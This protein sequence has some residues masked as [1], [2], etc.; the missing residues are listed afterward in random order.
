MTNSQNDLIEKL[1]EKLREIFQF[2][3]EDL[4]FGIYRI[5]NYKRKEIENFINKEIINEVKTQLSVLKEEEQQEIEEKIKEITSKTTIKKYLE[6]LEKG[7]EERIKLYREDFAED[8][9]EYENLKRKLKQAKVSENIEREIYNHLINFFSRYYDKGDFISKRRYGKKEKYIVPYNGEEILFYWVNKD[10]YYIKTTEYFRKYSFQIPDGNITVNFKVVKAEEEKGN[11]KSVEKKFFILSPEVFSLN[12]KELNIYFEYRTLSEKEKEKYKQGNTISQEKINKE[13]VKILQEKI[14]ENSLARIIF[15]KDPSSRTGKSYIEKHLYNYTKRNLTDYFI[16]KDLK[17]FL[18]R[19]LDFYIKNELLQLENLEILEQ[20]EYFDKL[21]LYLSEVKVFKN[22]ASK[23]I[24]FLAQ[25]ENFQ[26]KLWEKKKF[27]IDTHYVITLDKIKEYAGEEFLNDILSEILNNEKQLK[28]WQELFGIN[29]KEKKDLIDNNTLQGIEWKKL[30]IDTKH[31]NENFKWK[32]LTA[33]SKKN[34]LHKI[35]DGVLIKSENWQA[36]N[37]LLNTHY[38]KVKTI[39]IDPPFNKEQEADYLYKVGY[40]DATWIT[41]LENRIRLAKDL[42]NEKGSIFVRCDYNGNAYVRLLLNEIFGKE[43]FR[44]EISVRRFKKNVMEREIKKLPEGLDTIYVYA[45]NSEHF[46]YVNPFRMKD[47]KRE[48]FWRHMGD[49]SGQGNP[50]I[51]FGRELSPPP[52]KH[53]K[54]S[55]EKIDQMIK[56]GKLILQCK[57]CGYIHNRSNGLWKGCPV[58]GKDDPQP[59]YWVE[60]K[61][62]EVLDSNWS[63]IYGYSTKW[64]FQ[65]ENSETLL[66]RVIESTSNEGDTILDFFLGSGT[67][68]AVAHK[69]KRKW[70]GIEMG[71]HFWNIILPRMKKVLFYDPSGISKEK[72]VKEKYN[73]KTAGGFFKYHTLEQ[74]EDTLENIEFEDPQPTLYEFPDYFARYMFEWET[75]KSKAFLNISELKDPF[76]YKLKVI[77]NYHL[78]TFSVDMVETFNYLMGLTAKAYKAVEDNGRKYIFVFGEKEG[79]KIAIVWRSMKNLNLEKDRKLIEENIKRYGPDEI[80]INGDALVKNFKAIEPIF[81]TLMFEGAE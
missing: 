22:I 46:S 38:E 5:I 69:L 29:I 56:E 17:T 14:P 70:I 41:M 77:E 42:L 31:F 43:N 60:E 45:K 12:G 63:D 35:L 16:H 34:N 75:K 7:D 52:G 9:S 36:L 18:E 67:T 10:Q 57:H 11:V 58:C 76:N 64:K 25:I 62:T 59:K 80:Y 13:T 54:Y 65:T 30:P 27:I 37:L 47:E 28:E 55:Q 78:K 48:G 66:K 61:D 79:R 74:Y 6:A 19:E 44:N 2:E 32:L 53:W 24:E 81:K 20:K 39:Y 1:K 72:D 71:D 40:K 73:K 15:R 8:I 33:L 50:K 4:D 21:K 3:N 26:K 51:F 23:I 49:S 68:T